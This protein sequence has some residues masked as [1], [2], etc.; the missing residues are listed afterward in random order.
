MT[1][2][3]WIWAGAGAKLENGRGQWL[4]DNRGSETGVA[5]P[6]PGF[7]IGSGSFFLVWILIQTGKRARAMAGG[8]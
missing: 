5:D 2:L 8:Q 6:D 3:E 1:I 7:L 4:E